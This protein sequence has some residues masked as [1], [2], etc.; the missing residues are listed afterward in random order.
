M[1]R[2]KRQPELLG[3]HDGGHA[4]WRCVSM[5]AE[6]E[7]IMRQLHELRNY[8]GPVELLLANME[9]K[10]N[11]DRT[12]M[13]RKLEELELRLDALV[14]RNVDSRNEQLPEASPCA[15]RLAPDVLPPG[16]SV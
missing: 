12:D 4:D 10:M 8:L 16:A 3:R 11:K 5:N 13:A 2:R 15:T 1:S 7:E 9:A 6:I 14:K